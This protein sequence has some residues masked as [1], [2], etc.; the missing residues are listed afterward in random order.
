M[1]AN[2]QKKRPAENRRTAFAFAS[3]QLKTRHPFDD[4]HPAITAGGC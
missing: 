2:P 4:M 3:P 1:M